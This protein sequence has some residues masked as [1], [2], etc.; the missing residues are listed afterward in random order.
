MNEFLTRSYDDGILFTIP[1]QGIKTYHRIIR[2][3]DMFVYNLQS[4]GESF[5]WVCIDSVTGSCIDG[6]TW[7]HKRKEDAFKSAEKQYNRY[8]DDVLLEAHQN[9]LRQIEEGK[10]VKEGYFNKG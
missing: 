4:R 10:I 6:N 9:A 7:G 3:F 2:G 8:T 5:G 1:L